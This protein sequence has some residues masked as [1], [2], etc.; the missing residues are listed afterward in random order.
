MK[1]K[2]TLPAMSSPAAGLVLPEQLAQQAADAVRELLA[3]AAA[4]NTT[5]SYATALRYWAGWH[6][7]RF[8]AE[9]TLPVNE[10]VVIQFLVDHIQRKGKAGLV[11]ELPPTLDQTLV[12][13]GLKAK[14]GPLKL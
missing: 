2:D 14:V 5:R 4:A 3:E 13:A 7:G 8:G 10:A 1:R 11:S 12:A 9:L 6:L